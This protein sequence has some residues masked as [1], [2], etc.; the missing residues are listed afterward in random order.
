MVHIEAVDLSV[1]GVTLPSDCVGM[2]IVQPHLSLTE[3]EPFCCNT[4]AK[5]QQLAM[6]SETLDVSCAARHGAS[7]THFTIFPEYSIPS[8]E[9]IALIDAALQAPEWPNATIGLGVQ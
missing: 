7:R 8:P 1:R 5:P 4:Q 6:I 3:V 9:G 2:V